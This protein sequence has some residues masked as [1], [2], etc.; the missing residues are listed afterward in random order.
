MRLSQMQDI[1]GCRTTVKDIAT[2]NNIVSA[3]V[4]IFPAT[5]IDRREQPSHGYRAVHVIV[6]PNVLPIEIQVRTRLQHLWAEIS[7]KLAD[8]L[9]IDVKYGGG[10]DIARQSLDYMGDIVKRLEMLE[11]LARTLPTEDIKSQM[12]TIRND[13][14]QI[15]TRFG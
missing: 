9:G 6:R 10:P 11:Y 12:A 1:A 8:K 15:L 4:E 5:I 2:Q 13:I 7:E 3:I 14:E